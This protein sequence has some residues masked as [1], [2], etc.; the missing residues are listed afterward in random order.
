MTNSKI[1]D[2]SRRVGLMIGCFLVT[3]GIVLLVNIILVLLHASNPDLHNPAGGLRNFGHLITVLGLLAP[4][5]GIMLGATASSSDLSSGVIRHLVATG[6]GRRAIFVSRLLAGLFYIVIFCLI[7]VGLAALFAEVFA[8][9]ANSFSPFGGSFVAQINPSFPN[10]Y[11]SF[12][13]VVL[14]V[15]LG[16]ALGFGFCAMGVSRSA[17]TGVLIGFQIVALPILTNI[18]TWT[19]LHEIFG[20]IVSQT[21]EPSSVAARG[22]HLSNLIPLNTAGKV[23]II[24]IW[25]VIPILLGFAR[26]HSRDV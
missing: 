5:A 25:I 6:V 7:A 26:Y 8:G 17:A 20:G 10:I 11:Q 9:T 14:Q 15:A 2:L 24:G 22:S 13:W 1:M 4:I 21:L 16:Y 18:N 12:L 23:V 19:W 3:G